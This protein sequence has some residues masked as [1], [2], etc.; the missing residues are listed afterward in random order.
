MTYHVLSVGNFKNI[1]KELKCWSEQREN[2]LIVKAE[3]SGQTALEGRNTAFVEKW[4]LYGKA[5]NRPFDA[6]SKFQSQSGWRRKR[7]ELPSR[8]RSHNVWNERRVEVGEESLSLREKMA[9]E[10][11]SLLQMTWDSK[12]GDM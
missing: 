10:K 6:M 9:I 8:K 11:V 12:S 2:P 4:S 5:P 7:D 3:T 1:V